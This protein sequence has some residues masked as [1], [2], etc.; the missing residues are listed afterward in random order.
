[1]WCRPL[2]YLWIQYHLPT[3]AQLISSL[4]WSLIY[5][6]VA[7]N[8]TQVSCIIDVLDVL[9]EMKSL[10]ATGQQSVELTFCTKAHTEFQ[11][12]VQETKQEQHA[13]M[14]QMKMTKE[15]LLAEQQQ[16]VLQR[17]ALMSEEMHYLNAFKSLQSCNHYT[18]QNLNNLSRNDLVKASKSH[19]KYLRHNHTL[20]FLSKDEL[21]DLIKF[22]DTVDGR[23]F[24][25][26]DYSSKH[27]MINHGKCLER[28]NLITNL[29]QITNYFE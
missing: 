4:L 28:L 1:M 20:T 22:I 8:G 18:Q 23:V 16:N 15:S 14:E 6:L 26:A 17:Q 19:Q 21:I 9:A 5:Y 7:F 24:S 2:H 12:A 29:C 10:L 11:L 13:R 27:G 25:K 3:I